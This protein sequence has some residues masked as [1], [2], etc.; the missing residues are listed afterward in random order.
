MNAF[1]VTDNEAMGQGVRKILLKGGL[2]C[3]ASNVIAPGAVSSRL[4]QEQ[5]DVVVFIMPADPEK[6]VQ[7]LDRLEQLPR[8]SQTHVIAVGPAQDAKLVLRALRGAVDDYLDQDELEVELEAALGRLRTSDRMQGEAG[9]VITLL[10]PSGGSG[11]STLAVNLATVLAAKY[12]TTALVD[13]KLESG[14]VASLLDLKPQFTIADLCQDVERMDAALFERA[15]VRHDTGVHLLA[16]PRLLREVEQVS[17]EAVSQVL[18]LARSSFPFVLVDLDHSFRKEQAAALRHTDVLMIV[19]RL[20]F[21]S[22]RQTRRAIEY[23]VDKGFSQDHIRLVVNRYGQPKE[24]PYSKAEE[25]L[26]MKITHYVPDDPR[27]VNRANNNG[28]P[29]VLDAPSARISKSLSEL[30]YSVNGKSKSNA[31]H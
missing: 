29:M 19:L 3:A 23:V 26:G 30:A 27:T 12:K 13:L 2:N 31:E 9:K 14:D 28:V 6:A 24:I 4:E 7:A 16:A 18:Q 17:P 8:R 21:V 1:L 10:A 15:L 20:D 22:L 25:A 11:S 5:A